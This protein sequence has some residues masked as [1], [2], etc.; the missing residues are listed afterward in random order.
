LIRREAA[1]YGVG[2][3]HSELVGLIPQEALVEAARWYLQ[4]DAFEPAQI[5][6]RRL[7]T[8]QEEMALAGERTAC[9]ASAFLDALASATPTPGGGSAAAYC[10]AAGA[11]LVAMVAR[12]TVGRKKYAAVAE[13]MQ[14]M[15]TLAEDLRQRL[16]QAIDGDAAAFNA[17]MAAFKL[18][19][20][21]PEQ[22]QARVAAIESAALK[23][24]QVPLEVAGMAVQVMDLAVQAVSLGNQNAIS[25]GATGAGMAQAA[26]TGAGYNVRINLV[27][28]SD[29]Q[30]ASRMLEELCRLEARAEQFENQ[31]REQLAMRGGFEF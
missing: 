6:E 4:L 30:A 16:S 1:R 7:A 24:A 5:L 21:T 25:D 18:P 8:A 9:T 27:G 17:V 20:D 31:I 10:G 19:K 2:I 23:A 29:R 12:L 15:L 3:H 26:L 14:A 28:I 13:Q 22:E 11:A